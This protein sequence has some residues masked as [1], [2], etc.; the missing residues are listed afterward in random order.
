MNMGERSI[1]WLPRVCSHELLESSVPRREKSIDVS[2]VS[3]SCSVRELSKL[4]GVYIECTRS[5]SKV[6]HV[7]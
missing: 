5:N 6:W 2:F 7:I 1:S 4:E 3:M